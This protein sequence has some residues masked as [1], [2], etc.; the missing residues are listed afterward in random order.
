M[1]RKPT[2]TTTSGPA[3]GIRSRAQTGAKDK[4]KGRVQGTAK[5][6]S[7]SQAQEAQAMGSG[8]RTVTT[9]QPQTPLGQK[10]W[11]IR[12]RIVATGEPLLDEAGIR[13]DVAERR[14]GAEWPE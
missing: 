9:Y 7:R 1:S 10:L 6:R 13:R 14:G 3:P 11:A 8:Q 2:A 12:Q 5:G 4:G